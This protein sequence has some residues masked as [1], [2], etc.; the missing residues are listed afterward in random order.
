MHPPRRFLTATVAAVRV[1]IF[2]CTAVVTHLP[3]YS[4]LS[5]NERRTAL[6]R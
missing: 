1:S 4:A 5:P 6:L 3:W 2:G